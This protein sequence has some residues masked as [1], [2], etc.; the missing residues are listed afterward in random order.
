MSDTHI[1]ITIF[2]TTGDL[3]QRKLFPAF[4]NLFLGQQLQHFTLIGFGRRP[5]SQDDFEQLVTASIQ[6]VHHPEHTD[7][8]QQQFLAHCHYFQG[9]LDDKTSFSRL[10]DEITTQ[11]SQAVTSTCRFF[12]CATAPEFFPIIG[13]G[14]GAAGLHQP[15]QPSGTLP[16]LIIEKPFGHDLTSAK[17]LNHRL[18]HYFTEE[19]IYRI[20]HYLGKEAVQN[21][22]AFRFANG[23]FEPLWHKDHIDHIQ[24]TIAETLGVESRAGYYDHIGALRDIIQNHGLQ[25]LAHVTMEPPGSLTAKALRNTRTE[26]VRHYTIEQLVTGQYE[27]YSQEKNVMP[28]S[29]TET[30]AA[31]KITSSQPRWQDIPM[32]IRTGK[33]LPQR[34]TEISVQFKAPI[35]HLFPRAQPNILTFRITPYAGIALCFGVKQNN[36]ETLKQ[37]TMLFCFPQHPTKLGDYEQLLLDCIH[38][39]QSFFLR[40]DEVEAAWQLIS[41]VLSLQDRETPRI[42]PQNTWGPTT[43]NELISQDSRDWMIHSF[44]AC[45]IR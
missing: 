29:E 5:F 24:I 30:Y 40:A 41:P 9:D 13:E 6:T 17:E 34:A 21:L 32:Y 25:L 7:A 1:T 39:D 26:T 43:A 44:D 19:Q 37:H 20:D 23:L 36:Q 2:G 22:L 12:Y 8:K 16:R 10:R 18:A 28:D 45:E 38:G 31:V 15:S 42:Y 14:L 4:Y 27:G 33:R 3:A 11:E 35:Q